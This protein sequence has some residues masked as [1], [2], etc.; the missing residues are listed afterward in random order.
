[1]Y[2]F[3]PLRHTGGKE[4]DFHPI[5]N[6]DLDVDEESTPHPRRFIPGKDQ[7]HNEKEGAGAPEPRSISW[8]PL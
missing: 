8:C 4:V 7:I 1:M 3:I 2:F 6:S 5:L